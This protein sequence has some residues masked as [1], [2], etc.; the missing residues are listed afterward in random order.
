MCVTL[1]AALLDKDREGTREKTGGTLLLLHPQARP[2]TI[3]S[4]PD[5]YVRSYGD[6]LSLHSDATCP[7]LCSAQCPIVETSL[8]LA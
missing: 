5:L 8:A 4:A 6:L 3:P 2:I 7:D 1:W